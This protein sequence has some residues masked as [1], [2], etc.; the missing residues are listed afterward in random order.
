M[1]LLDEIKRD[2]EDGTPGPWEA[3]HCKQCDLWE[4]W[5]P[6]ETEILTP[7]FVFDD[8]IRGAVLGSADA[9]RIA[10]VPDMEDHIIAL[11]TENERLRAALGESE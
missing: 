8:D 3:D 5:G 2:R 1:T 11:E 7:H 6:N 4:I 9:R 10:R